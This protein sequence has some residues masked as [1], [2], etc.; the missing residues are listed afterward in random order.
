MSI[1]EIA[2]I[3]AAGIG[4]RLGLNMPKCLVPI[5]GQRIIDY[6]LEFLQEVDEVRVVVGFM[7]EK[8]IHH[9]KQR[10]PDVIFVRNPY[11]ISTST[12]QSICLA[13][14]NLKGPFLAV[15]GDLIIEPES[16]QAFLT[17]CAQGAPL[18]GVTPASTEDAVFVRTREKNDGSLWVEGFQRDSR[19][20][21][22]W[23]GLAFLDAR[24]ISFENKFVYQSLEAYLP[25]RA[26]VIHCHEIDT[27]ADLLRANLALHSFVATPTFQTRELFHAA[28]R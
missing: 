24:H 25:L 7:E 16:G 4:S 9:V 5:G 1:V 6:Q 8:V 27:Q 14:R 13:A 20:R 18:I 2:I 10:R 26:E 23:T 12:L 17:Q 28:R 22:E 21:L 19:T 15:D 3:S 11:Y